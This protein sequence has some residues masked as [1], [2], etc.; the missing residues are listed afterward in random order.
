MSQIWLKLDSAG[1]VVTGSE[2]LIVF[3]QCPER[4]CSYACGVTGVEFKPN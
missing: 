1:A 4:G 3:H 2:K